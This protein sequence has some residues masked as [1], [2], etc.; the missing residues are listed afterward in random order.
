MSV[1]ALASGARALARIPVL[2][3]TSFRHSTIF[4]TVIAISGT[5]LFLELPRDFLGEPMLLRNGHVPQLPIGVNVSKR[6][7]KSFYQG[8][9]YSAGQENLQLKS[10][11]FPLPHIS[12]YVSFN[13]TKR[14]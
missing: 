9:A 11:P 4:F 14:R 7:L 1:R 13:K 5:S 3:S 6:S 2:F 8:R 12:S 10:G